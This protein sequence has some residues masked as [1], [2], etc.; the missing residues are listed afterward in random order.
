MPDYRS[1]DCSDGEL[2]QLEEHL[3][4]DGFM[5]TTKSNQKHILPKEY[6]KRTYSGTST[7]FEG[8]RRWTIT[9]RTN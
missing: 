5:L 7:S 3:K 4:K 9:C 1:F 2:T 6:F 8:P